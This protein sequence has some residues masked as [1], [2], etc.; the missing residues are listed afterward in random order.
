MKLTLPHH[1]TQEKAIKILDQ[2]ARE[3]IDNAKK[4]FPWVTIVDPKK[5]WDDNIL[6]F[7][8][9]VEK[10]MMTLDFEGLIIITDRAV[11]GETDIPPIVT[12][13]FPEEII[14]EKITAEFNKLFNITGLF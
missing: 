11:I 4:D 3:L 6:R 14:R 5:E 9:T 1:T 8:F 13:F 7:S 10:M 2:K 12:T